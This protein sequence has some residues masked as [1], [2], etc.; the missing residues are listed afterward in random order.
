MSHP[1]LIIMTSFNPYHFFTGLI[2]K[3]S[4]TGAW[5][6]NIG[7]YGDTIWPIA[8]IL[9]DYGIQKLTSLQ[10]SPITLGEV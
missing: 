4:H 9:K 6:F 1:G 5:S 7:I 10:T 3:C 2:S 8:E